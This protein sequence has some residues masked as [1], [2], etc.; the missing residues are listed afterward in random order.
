MAPSVI[1]WFLLEKACLIYLIVSL[2]ERVVINLLNLLLL[3][4]FKNRHVL[5]YDPVD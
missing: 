5:G 2:L 4:L 3:D 1:E